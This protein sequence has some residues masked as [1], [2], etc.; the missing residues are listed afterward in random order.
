VF[1]LKVLY[2]ELLP[3]IRRLVDARPTYDYRRIP[4]LL[5]RERRLLIFGS[6]PPRSPRLRWLEQL[7]RTTT[8]GG[9]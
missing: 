6:P 8:L 3:A 1:N 4:A 2:A 7:D 9:G 5:N